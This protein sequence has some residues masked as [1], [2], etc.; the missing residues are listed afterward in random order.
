[1]YGSPRLNNKFEPLDELFFILISQMTTAPSYERVFDRLKIA[2]GDWRQLPNFDIDALTGIIAEAGL[3]NQKAP[4]I[5][6]I[7]RR[8]ASD[9]GD[10][11]LD[12]LLE[13]DNQTAE[14]YL[15]S[16]PGVGTK[17]AKCVLLYALNRTVLP[18]D[19]HVGRLAARLGLIDFRLPVSRVHAELETVVP[20]AA[21][22]DF[23]VNGVMH[24][25]KICRALRPHCGAC[26]LQ[27]LCPSAGLSKNH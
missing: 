27:D 4:R 9:F 1:M 16:L 10:V 18:V 5:I 23:H 2:V 17:T 8:L 14:D 24:G 7:A 25:R 11:T 3:S 22:Y 6:A 19:T 12:P 13:M 20:A 26:S 15:T 21:R